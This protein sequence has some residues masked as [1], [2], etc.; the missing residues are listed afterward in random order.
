MMGQLPAGDIF[1]VRPERSRA[2]AK[3]KGICLGF[4]SA[5]SAL[6]SARTGFCVAVALLLGACATSTPLPE[7][8]SD[9][10]NTFRNGPSEQPAQPAPDLQNWWHAFGDEH[11]NRL[12]ERA[13]AQNL[14]LQQAQLRLL[15]ARALHHKSGTQF[16]PQLSFHTFAQPDPNGSTSYFEIGFDADWEF[17]FFGRRLANTRVA[18]ADLQAAATDLVAAR[19]TLIAEVA[20]NYVD[21]RAAQARAG[22]LDSIVA[23]RRQNRELGAVRLRLNLATPADVDKLDTELAQATGEAAEP[24]QAIAQTQAALALLLAESA[25]DDDLRAAGEP[26]LLSNVMFAETPADLLRTRPEIRKA[27]LD[28][29]R[30]AG[31]LGIARADLWPKLALGGFLISSTRMVGDINRPNKAIV[32]V[33]PAI[34]IPIFD[35][36]M[37]RD[38]VNAREAALQVAVLGYKQAVLE[39]VAEAESALAQWQRAQAQLGAAGTA[40]IAAERGAERTRKLQGVGLADNANAAN[41]QIASAQAR[42]N[43][44]LAQR[45]A[46][47]AFIAVYKSFGGSLPP[48]QMQ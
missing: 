19:A 33:G 17:G 44:A 8:P 34:Q 39:G 47:I 32:G 38:V 29:L 4:D 28:V 12:I 22:L 7:L 5:P 40:V 3:S 45:D 15:A 27:E 21:L 1:A 31:E 26:P 20:R 43:H 37:R 11:L 35:W 18:A 42:L 46:S 10:P 30:A 13:L 48:L 9:V 24:A 25:P 36:G 2:A 16:E 41:A 14:T 6:R 23:A